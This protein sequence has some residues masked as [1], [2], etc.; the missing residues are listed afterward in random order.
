MPD[1]RE[2]AE[3]VEL[4]VQREPGVELDVLVGAIPRVPV[5]L[6]PERARVP[7]R[8]AE[9]AREIQ[10]RGIRRAHGVRGHPEVRRGHA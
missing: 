8:L 4:D 9:P 5:P 3:V 1:R 10:H 7:E 6:D 2:T